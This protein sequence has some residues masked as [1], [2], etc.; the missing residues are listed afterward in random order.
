MNLSGITKIEAL[1]GTNYD[2]WKIHM[3]AVLI[4]CDLWCYVN[5]AIKKPTVDENDRESVAAASKWRNYD[6]KAMSEIL[7]GISPCELK[8]V[9]NCKTSS[10]LWSKLESTYES[11]GPARKATLL[12]RLVLRKM[13]SGGDVREHLK[14]FFDVVDKLE[15]MEVPINPDLLSI[16]LL[17]SLPSTFETFRCAIES[18]DDLPSPETL[19]I[20][21]VEEYDART[22]D[23]RNDVPDALAI[24]KNG[25][26]RFPARKKA[27]AREA[28]EIGGKPSFRCFRCNE[29]GHRASECKQAR[30]DD[31][32]YTK[33]SRHTSLYAEA[34]R[35]DT[36][37]DKKWCLDSGCTSHLC[38]DANRF[39]T[40]KKAN[41][42]LLNLASN[43][44]TTV[45]G[46][47]TVEI[48]TRVG[49]TTRNI[50][51][52]ET[53]YIPDLRSNLL[54]VAKIT[55]RDLD[56][57]FNKYGARVLD[58][59]GNIILKANRIG[60]LY[61]VQDEKTD[62]CG[63]ISS[64]DDDTGPCND[65]ETW[66]RR[67][68]HTNVDDIRKAK[69]RQMIRGLEKYK[70]SGNMICEICAQGKM[71]RAPFSNKSKRK[72]M[73]LEIIHSDICGP[74]RTESNGGSLYFVTFIDDASRWCEVR[75]L[76]RKSE[77]FAAFRE[78]K[79]M[80]EN[81]SGRKI[82]YL[83]SDNGR[84]YVNE[85]FDDFLKE[86]GIQ[87]RLTVPRNPEQ[88]GLAERKNRTLVEMARCLLIQSGLPPSFWAE[89]IST[90]NYIRNRCPTKSLNDTTPFEAWI[91]RKPSVAHLREFGCRVYCLNT[92]KQRGKF[93]ARAR[94]GVLIGYA[95][96]AK[97]YKIWLTKER[98]VEISRDVRFSER[99]TKVLDGEYRSFEPEELEVQ[100]SR[101]HEKSSNELTNGNKQIASEST[102]ARPEEPRQEHP[103]TTQET[104]KRRPGRPRILRTG[105]RGR[106]RKLY[107]M[108]N[109]ENR[110]ELD[111]D[112][113]NEEPNENEVEI[114][115]AA[116]I[117]AKCALSGNEREE[118]KQAMAEEVRSIIKNDA[119]TTV[120][121]SPEN[122]SVGSRF[123]L[124]NKYNPDGTLQ[125]RKA[126]IVAQGFAQRPGIDFFESFAPV[127][128]LSSI[129]LMTAL[130]AQHG[131]IIRQFDVSTA[132]LNAT[133]EEDVYMKVPEHFREALDQVVRG[134][135]NA[136]IKR[137]ATKML[138]DLRTGDKVFHLKKALYGLRQAGRSWYKTLD[139][140]L[141]NFGAEPTNADPCIYRIERGEEST[142]IAIYVDDILIAA[143]KPDDINRVRDHLS[144]HFEVNDLGDV[145]CCLGIEFT[146]KGDKI[147]INQKGYIKDTV[148][149]FG[150]TDCNP[151]NTPMDP[152][153]K[154]QK[155]EGP[156]NREDSKLP[157]RELIGS[158]MYLAVAT[159]PD[160]AYTVSYLSQF[161]SCYDKTHW[162]AAKRVL[163]YL[164][165]TM[166]LSIEYGRTDEPLKGYVD[167]D[168]ANCPIDRRSYTGYAYVLASGAI[169]WNSR[170]QQTVALSS[171]EAEYMAL[172]EAA[173][174][175]VFLH[176]F[177][178]ELGFRQLADVN[179]YNDNIGASRMADNPVFHNRTKHIDVRHH[180]VRDLIKNGHITLGHVSTGDMPADV[181]TKALPRAKHVACRERLGMA[182]PVESR[183]EGKY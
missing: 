33:A 181:L 137:R 18:R 60:G 61:C 53:L 1:T 143:Q 173:K 150:M 41:H 20:K 59:H 118:W 182:G 149:N 135:T 5:S 99:K 134:E 85:Q 88:N 42:S 72:T 93:E 78:V 86:N 179:I 4:K 172:A 148:K 131:M 104:P 77:A 162:A 155:R 138:K 115:C 165:H 178:V 151:I 69:H 82:K 36:S 119:W 43:A 7:L 66:H 170:K 19:R 56:V 37:R 65:L 28:R 34:L 58:K 153:T 176:A 141:R 71:T 106:P 167:A 116:E 102:N 70:L 133:L 183:I 157:Y 109:E 57:V 177:L 12:K 22:N 74:M 47:G 145:E 146:R 161:L 15:A 83:Q 8:Q 52:E 90:S 152:G 158:L 50:N 129:R 124:R 100:E 11:K 168:W 75:F 169:S 81:F 49:G 147:Q 117:P 122:S 51:L 164:K 30:G 87:R 73:P 139:K 13:Q 166:D 136:N 24:N 46:R 45:D 174:E 98:K 94:E 89:A 14:S 180:F 140:E 35:V 160:I 126:R 130:A 163:R 9:K 3:R 17:Y 91:G 67:L 68:G 25:R 113:P 144:K 10:E 121:K 114:A 55:D 23:D 21:I 92:N 142:I 108:Q 76:R 2:T 175:A 63:A 95:E 132:Y 48:V 120:D 64:P 38:N 62:E 101:T 154:L 6:E 111:G 103:E 110:A 16:L 26:E 128:R 44:T 39:Q 127:A 105:N 27:S 107:N 80:L 125:R 79:K 32:R 156:A 96:Q 84:E 40:I 97:G 171:T 29:V 112:E 31:R 159:R 123:V 54:S